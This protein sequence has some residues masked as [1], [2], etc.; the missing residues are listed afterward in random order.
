ML[1]LDGHSS[2]HD[3]AIVA[4]CRVYYIFI[5]II[6][7]HT[8]HILQPLDLVCNG[9][10]KRLLND[11]FEPEPGLTLQQ[12]RSRLLEISGYALQGALIAMN[13]ISSFK[14]SG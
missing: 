6:P 9:Q 2:R 4:V 7:A 12:R 1:I 10:F 3:A 13:I 8:S 5:M 11:Y 14:R